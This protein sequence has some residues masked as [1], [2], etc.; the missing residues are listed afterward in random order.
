[1]K[2]RLKNNYI[3]FARISLVL[4]YLVIL[5]GAVVRM[6]GSGMGCPDWPKCFGYLIPPTEE[7][8]LEW[9]PGRTFREGQVIIR[10][11]SLLLARAEFTTGE[12]FDPANWEPYTRHDYAVF[13]AFHTW[14]EYINRLLGALAGLA[15]LI[16]ALSSLAWWREARG[17]VLF[18]WLTVIAIGFQGWLGATVVYSVLAPV[19]IT[20]H[21][22][23]AMVL[24]G[25]LL[26]IVFRNQQPAGN[27]VGDRLTFR[28]W[29]LTVAVSLL[30][31]I[32][33]TQVRQYVDGQADILG[34]GA[35][36][37]WLADP[38]WVFYVHRSFS[39]LVLLLHLWVAWRIRK[40]RLGFD[41]V[42]PT[43]LI[44]FLIIASGMAMA[45]LD[46]P[47]GSQPV[48]LVLASVLFGFQWFLLLEMYRAARARISS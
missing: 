32:L 12:A 2:E 14:T 36:D 22:M 33:G 13:N 39:I 29:V 42:L 11:E 27:Q 41:K 17:K 23:M 46:F 19:R 3:R 28:L 10:E 44:L 24:L 1:M 7:S 40:L 20:L 6:T 34:Y 26:W 21:M 31:I 5:A 8:Q 30:Q 4:V 18:A 45:Y 16:M 15:I 38:T 43:L 9:A 48:H 47:W 37:L 25:M 35:R